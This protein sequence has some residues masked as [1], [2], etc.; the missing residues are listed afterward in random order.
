MVAFTGVSWLGEEWL[1]MD[2]DVRPVA[3]AGADAVLDALRDGMGV[4]NRQIGIDADVDFDG[5]SGAEK[6]LSDISSD[7]LD[8]HGAKDYC[9]LR[10]GTIR[11]LSS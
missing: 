2:D 5:D 8:H 10:S 9:C 4:A 1:D 3:V 11:M 6:P 7:G